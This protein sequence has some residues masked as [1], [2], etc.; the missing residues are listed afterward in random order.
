MDAILTDPRGAWACGSN[1]TERSTEPIVAKSA[2]TDRANS[3][4]PRA[5]PRIRPASHI[6]CLESSRVSHRAG[7][8]WAR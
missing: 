2:A 3:S 1:P 8:A 4:G 7:S 6:H 5:P